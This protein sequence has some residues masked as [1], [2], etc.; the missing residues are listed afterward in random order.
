MYTHSYMSILNIPIGCDSDNA[1]SEYI[2]IILG[3]LVGIR[4]ENIGKGCILTTRFWDGKRINYNHM[5]KE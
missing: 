5:L 4:G 1:K 2:H 3:I